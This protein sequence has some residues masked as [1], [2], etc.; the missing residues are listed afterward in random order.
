MGYYTYFSLSTNATEDKEREIALWMID[1]LDYFSFCS[2]ERV[3]KSY[4][5]LDYVVGSDS[6][7]WYDHEDDMRKVAAAF[8]DVKFE[9]YGEGEERDDIWREFYWNDRFDCDTA[10][11]VWGPVPRWMGEKTE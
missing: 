8:P 7:K 11:I 2:K 4:E 1:N 3:S 5:P 10:Q 6:M 9:L